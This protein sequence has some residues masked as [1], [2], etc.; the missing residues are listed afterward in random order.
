[1]PGDF[2]QAVHALRSRSRSESRRYCAEGLI[3]KRIGTPNMALVISSIPPIPRARIAVGIAGKAWLNIVRR[4][5]GLPTKPLRFQKRV[6]VGR[7]TVS[8]PA[9][10]KPLKTL[11]NGKT[12]DKQIKP[13][14]FILGCH[15]ASSAIRS[16]PI[17]SASISSRHTRS[18]RESGRQALDR[19]VFKRR[20]ALSHQHVGAARLTNMARVKSYGDVLRGTSTIPNRSAPMPAACRA[21]SKPLDCSDSGISRS[22]VRLHRQGV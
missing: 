16:V 2:R 7:T 5:L 19:S 4:S 21:E 18:I 14:N 8:S 11:N 6:A 17:R 3:T 12:Y 15:V 10:M 22:T 1:M 13:F 20:E 9:V